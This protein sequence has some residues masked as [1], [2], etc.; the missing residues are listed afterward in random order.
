MQHS[1]LTLKLQEI[2]ERY[3]ALMRQAFQPYDQVIEAAREQIERNQERLV[4]LI[5]GNAQAADPRAANPWA[6]DEV[7]DLRSNI[8]RLE[9]VMKRADEEY[10][11]IKHNIRLAQDEE[12]DTLGLEM[13][14]PDHPWYHENRHRMNG[15]GM[16]GGSTIPER[17]LAAEIRELH[18]LLNQGDRK[19]DSRVGQFNLLLNQVVHDKTTAPFDKEAMKLIRSVARNNR[20]EALGRAPSVSPDIL[21]NNEENNQ[22]VLALLPVIKGREKARKVPDAAP[23]PAASDEAE[24]SPQDENKDPL[25]LLSGSGRGDQWHSGQNRRYGHR[26]FR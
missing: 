18:P 6:Y 10:T 9:A 26:S 20:F 14:N 23:V 8:V 13:Q 2:T 19:A 11:F 16:R 24:E 25:D 17:G 21:I 7:T 15:S 12:L 4:E 1:P 22:R 3:S 5:S